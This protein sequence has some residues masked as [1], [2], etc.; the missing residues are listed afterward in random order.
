MNTTLAVVVSA[1]VI[2]ITALVVITI[3]SGGMQQI[4]TISNARTLCETNYRTICMGTGQ[5]PS[6]WGIGNMNVNGAIMSCSQVLNCVCDNNGGR[7]PY[8]VT[9][10]TPI[11]T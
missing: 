8:T 5:Q 6:T 2:L 11:A 9:Q 10:C 1:I 7:G 4:G 3:F